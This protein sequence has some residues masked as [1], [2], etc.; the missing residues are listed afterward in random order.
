M[1]KI[2]L[3][4]LLAG[5]TF[6]YGNK[7]LAADLAETQLVAARAFV[8]GIGYV[9]YITPDGEIC[10]PVI[11]SIPQKPYARVDQVNCLVAAGASM[12]QND[13]LDAS[14]GFDPLGIVYFG[15]TTCN[16]PIPN[17]N[18]NPDGAPI[19]FIVG[20]DVPITMSGQA[21]LK[22]FDPLNPSARQSVNHSADARNILAAS[23]SE[24]SAAPYNTPGT[25][26][27]GLSR[28]LFY[29]TLNTNDLTKNFIVA[30]NVSLSL[31]AGWIWV[32]APQNCAG[33][34][35]RVVTC[36]QESVPFQIGL[37]PGEPMPT[38]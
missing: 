24:T 17:L 34:L 23:Y 31:P 22:Y 2:G 37:N 35:T 28:G 4:L 36:N 13:P 33:N 21:Y 8:S 11:E 27:W 16:R 7:T 10:L 9:C 12:K 6:F 30:H 25:D 20:T 26:N 5:C 18:D 3:V 19:R 32:S 15:R 1:K 14:K 38:P 29:R